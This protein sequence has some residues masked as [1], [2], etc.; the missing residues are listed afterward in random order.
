MATWILVVL[1]IYFIQTMSG[2]SARWLF[3]KKARVIDALGPRDDP[4]PQSRIGG[5]LDRAAAN[6]QEALFLFLPLA[7]LIELKGGPTL[8]A[9]MAAKTFAAARALYVPAYAS[10][11][12]GLRSLIWMIGHAA[13]AVLT[14]ILLG[15]L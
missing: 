3:G 12:F 5:R 10:G 1:G 4:P 15:R 8:E 2:P 7:L 14:G 9:L 13:L 11:I 6:M